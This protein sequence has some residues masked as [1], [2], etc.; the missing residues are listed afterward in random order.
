MA[1]I[2]WGRKIGGSIEK[3]SD[4]SA[5]RRSKPVIAMVGPDTT[6]ESIEV[7]DH[8]P[9]MKQIINEDEEYFVLSSLSF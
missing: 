2:L 6:I 7:A 5:V 9:P 4:T 8:P 3:C 1:A